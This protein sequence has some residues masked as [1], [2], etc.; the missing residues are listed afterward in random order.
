MSSKKLYDLKYMFHSGQ[1]EGKTVYRIS[2]GYGGLH[3]VM[4]DSNSRVLHYGLIKHGEK[5]IESK[6]PK[7]TMLTPMSMHLGLITTEEHLGAIRA[8][9]NRKE[10]IKAAEEK[11]T[12]VQRELDELKNEI[13]MYKRLKKKFG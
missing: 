1:M 6:P 11:E 12:K 7:L 9:H 4:I 10:A 5:G 8:E 13:S 2:H 3:I